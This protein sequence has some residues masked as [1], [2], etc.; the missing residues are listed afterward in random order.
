[1]DIELLYK[2]INEGIRLQKTKAHAIEFYTTI[3][4]LS[5]YV[6]LNSKIIEL[7]AGEGIYAEEFKDTCFLYHA[8]DLV[9]KHI[10]ILN[11]KFKENKNISISKINAIDVPKELFNIYDIILCFGP[12][13][14]LQN[15]EDRKK[16]ILN[17]IKLGCED[18]IIAFSY[19]CK[20]FVNQIYIKYDK[21][22]TA[23]EYISFEEGLN[24]EIS[25]LDDFMG[26]AYFNT[27]EEIENE[28]L[29]CNLE[30][31]DHLRTDGPYVLQTDKINK[32]SKSEYEALLKYHE[33]TCRE[34]SVL[35][36]TNHGMVICRKKPSSVSF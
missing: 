2:N 20:S 9:Q 10:D 1:M 34:K 18:S 36:M 17:C 7:G 25:Y 33:R 32:M 12:Y 13:Y 27:P 23:S 30:I 31:I 22:F 24:N 21:N 3:N 29:E 14:H 28:L 8:T 4:A 6:H 15:K 19:I 11:N 5:K 16:C 35:G 26:L